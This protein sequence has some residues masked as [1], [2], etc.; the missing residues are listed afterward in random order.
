[1]IFGRWGLRRRW[2][3]HCLIFLDYNII[4]LCIT[5]YTTTIGTTI[6]IINII[7]I[8]ITPNESNRLS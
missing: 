4:I 6:I 7:L 2:R 5:Y 1:M 8:Y 3:V